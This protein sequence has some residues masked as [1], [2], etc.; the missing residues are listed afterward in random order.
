M[1]KK[2]IIRILTAAALAVFLYSMGNLLAIRLRYRAG[3]KLYSDASEN[4]T[5]SV[6]S[7]TPES[8]LS[9]ETPVSEPPAEDEPE[10][11]PIVVDFQELQELNGD[12]FAWIYCEDSV[13]NYPVGFRD[14]LPGGAL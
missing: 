9:T 6:P 10:R 8:V 5:Q 13:I 3:E 14:Q 11:A 2:W 7:P 12:I 1:L 4:Y